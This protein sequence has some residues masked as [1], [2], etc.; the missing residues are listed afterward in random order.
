MIVDTIEQRKGYKHTALGRIPEDWEVTEVGKV[1][2]FI[3][4][5]RNKPTKFDGEI[6]WITTPD[7]EENISVCKSRLNLKVSI[8]E[9]KH[10]GSK[11]VPK[12]SIIISCVGDLGLVAIAGTDI[13]INQ[14]LHAFIPTKV[15]RSEFLL[16]ALNTQKKYM[17]RVATKTAV[18]YM[19]KDNCNSIPILLPPL[20]EQKAIADLLGTWDKAIATITQLIA[21]KEQRKKWLMQQLLTGKK[22]LPGFSGE[23]KYS[24][25]GSI[26]KEVS[27]KNRAD[28]NLIVLSC[29]KY[30]G[31][32]SSLEYF[33]RKIFS[34][35]LSTYKVVPKQCF[36]YATNHI[37]EGSIGYQ[38][39]FEEALISPMYT[40]FKTS[41]INDKFLFRLLKSHNYIH[42]YQKRME[43]SIDRRGGLR[44]EEFSK[45]KV[46]IPSD[47]EQ[48]AIVSILQTADSEIQLL[49]QKLEK[50]QEQKKG[51]MQVLLTG[52]K[53]LLNI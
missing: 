36:A 15:V 33:G 1:C 26:A 35:D 34:D 3:V 19:N 38:S 31:L 23:W 41:E 42:E 2:D 22:R 17:E 10:I 4:P 49:R 24:P 27:V 11:I 32:V 37:E 8:E 25:I 7:I 48:V 16:Y 47:E 46:P 45:I 9:A 39:T 52:K 20:P 18:P 14:Q 12:N 50:Q 5:G 21:Q 29:T 51:L 13:V 53:R 30:D 28:K 40:V 43:G 6:P 44:W